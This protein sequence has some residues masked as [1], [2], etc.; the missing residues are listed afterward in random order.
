MTDQGVLEVGLT[1][2]EDDDHTDATA[3]LELKGMT[4]H[5]RGRAR[6]N[7]TDPKVP[8]IGEELAVARALNEL[9]H[10]LL[11]AAANAIGQWS[12]RPADLKV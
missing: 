3:S 7:P 2:E 5:G 12:G 8:I 4:F 6:R 1:I 9:S 10:Q 11:E